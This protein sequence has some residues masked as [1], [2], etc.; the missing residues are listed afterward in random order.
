MKILIL[1][2]RL[3]KIN[4]L[5]SAAVALMGVEPEDKLTIKMRKLMEQC[6]Q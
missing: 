6:F 3:K 2:L 1:R 5:N 4:K